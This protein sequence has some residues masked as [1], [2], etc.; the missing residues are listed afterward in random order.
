MLVGEPDREK[1]EKKTKSCTA[2]VNIKNKKG[3]PLS[4]QASGGNDDEEEDEE[5]GLRNF[6]FINEVEME[7]Q[8]ENLN[9]FIRPP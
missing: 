5:H 3:C 6:F 2:E 9:S 1:I 7:E 8:K 4:F